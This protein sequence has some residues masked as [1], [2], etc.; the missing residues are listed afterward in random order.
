MRMLRGGIG[1]LRPHPRRKEYVEAQRLVMAGRYVDQQSQNLPVRDGFQMLAHALDVPVIH[2]STR[3]TG[4]TPTGMGIRQQRF[5]TLA[6][7]PIIISLFKLLT[8]RRDQ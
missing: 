3:F 5:L 4:P 1:V 6:A 8:D 2:K 7:L